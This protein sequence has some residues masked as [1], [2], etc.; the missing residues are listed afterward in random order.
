[1]AERFR[2]ERRKGKW[3]VLAMQSAET[4]AEAAWISL[5]GCGNVVT[6]TR[7]WL[8]CLGRGTRQ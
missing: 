2:L 4:A 3:H 8:A 7:V 6:A 1:M 5:G